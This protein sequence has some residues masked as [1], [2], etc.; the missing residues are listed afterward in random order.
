MY[1]KTVMEQSAMN[2]EL[3]AAYVAYQIAP[4][5]EESI[6]FMDCLNAIRLINKEMSL[7]EALKNKNGS[8]ILTIQELRKRRLEEG[9]PFCLVFPLSYHQTERRSAVGSY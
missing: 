8:I 5:G 3:E 6:L 9:T 1:F 4:I 7:R 2:A